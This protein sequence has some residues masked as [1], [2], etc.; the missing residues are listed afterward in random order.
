MNPTLDNIVDQAIANLDAEDAGVVNDTEAVSAEEVS[1]ENEAV[2]QTEETKETE[3]SEAGDAEE[4]SE[5]EDS[6][7]EYSAD[8]IDVDVPD[9]EPVAETKQ[10]EQATNLNPEQSFIFNNLP[11][12]NVTGADGKV[13]TIKVPSQLPA[14]FDFAN[15]REEVIFNQNVAAQE[16]NA[17]DLQGQFRNQQQQ[18]QASTFQ[19][20]VNASIRSDVAELQNDGVFPKFK[21][22]IDSPNFEKDPAAVEMQKVLDLMEERNA[23]YLESAQQGGT[24]RF[25]GFKEAYDIYTAQEARRSASKSVS[26]EDSAR[27]TI[28]RKTSNSAGERESNI[29]KPSV[30]PGT[31]TRDLLA[32]I[33]SMDF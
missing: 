1:E 32:E 26:D 8:E 2:E 22:P 10:P 28:A 17:R 31:T 30:R 4:S 15:K 21:T 9:E 18:Q 27:K 3:Q 20:A 14:D 16:L 6:G 24:Y 11:D 33:D 13:Y 23:G 12:I 19:E 25:I 7:V 29:I 5:E